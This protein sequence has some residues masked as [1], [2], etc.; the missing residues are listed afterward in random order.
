MTLKEI[1]NKALEIVRNYEISQGRDPHRVKNRGYDIES[2]DLKIEVK[3]RSKEKAPH[4]LLNE[5]NIRAI[6]KEKENFKLYIVLSPF[7]NPKLIIYSYDEVVGKR[8]ERRQW[9]ISITKKDR[10]KA[11]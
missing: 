6:E 5:Y 10:D 11:I 3:A 4:V 8:N 7:K 1:E 9:K 2:G